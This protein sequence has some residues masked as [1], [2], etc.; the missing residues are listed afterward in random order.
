MGLT[1]PRLEQFA[2][3]SRERFEQLLT[4]IT[5]HSFRSALTIRTG[6]PE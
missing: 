2:S 4:V 3:K 1:G 5:Q 6:S